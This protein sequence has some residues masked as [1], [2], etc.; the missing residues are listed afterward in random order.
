MMHEAKDRAMR[1]RFRLLGVFALCC[2]SLTAQQSTPRP[3]DEVLKQMGEHL[4][5]FDKRI[6]SVFC[7]EHVDS[8][9]SSETGDEAVSRDFTF[10]LKRTRDAHGE[11]SF[12]ESRDRKEESSPDRSTHDK[13][14][15]ST[16]DGGFESALALISPEQAQCLR[17]KLTTGKGTDRHD[18]VS[19]ETTK[20]SADVSSCILNEASHGVAA[21]DPRTHQLSHLEIVTPKHLIERGLWYSRRVIGKRTIAVDYAPTLL[22][23][24]MFWL[25]T[26]ISMHATGGEGTFHAATW[27]YQATYRGCHKTEVNVRLDTDDVVVQP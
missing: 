25:P 16:L 24:E 12:V 15:P 26:L 22:G 13:E 10:R 5:H 27:S 17:Y 4:I 7:E 9:L 21:I 2:L 18:Q 1:R 20:A 23:D 3:I 14:L 8:Q 19:F 11:L 6:S